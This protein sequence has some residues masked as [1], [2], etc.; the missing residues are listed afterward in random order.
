[1]IELIMQQMGIEPKMIQSVVSGIQQITSKL[2][3]DI[4]ALRAETA[5]LQM[6]IARLDNTIAGLTSGIRPA[7]ILPAAA[8]AVLIDLFATREEPHE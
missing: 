2:D 3:T 5:A 6:Q 4:T 1:M 8:E 7:G